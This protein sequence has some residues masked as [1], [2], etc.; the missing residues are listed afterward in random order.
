MANTYRARWISKQRLESLRRTGHLGQSVI[1]ESFNGF[2]I[3]EPAGADLG[4]GE[5]MSV[6]TA[7]Y[8]L[9]PVWCTGAKAKLREARK[10]LGLEA[11]EIESGRLIGAR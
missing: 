3:V 1:L 8:E 9:R 11:N 7:D 2:I 10:L 6:E 4:D 5:I